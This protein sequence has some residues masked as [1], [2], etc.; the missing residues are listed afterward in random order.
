MKNNYRIIKEWSR[1]AHQYVWTVQK[2]IF[3]FWINWETTYLHLDTLLGRYNLNRED[4]I[5]MT[6]KDL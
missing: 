1:E 3:W 5:D 4:V 6:K 2:K